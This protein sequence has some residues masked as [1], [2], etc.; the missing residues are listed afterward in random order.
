MSESPA[1]E[2]SVNENTEKAAEKPFL[3]V[4]NGNPT[5]ED[6]AV[7]VSVLAGAGAGG[8]EPEPEIRNDWGRP[9][10]RLRP[11]WGAPSSFTNLRY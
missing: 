6:L 11:Q 4:V 9:V 3:T 2:A 5:D 1:N 8:G 7:L 10:D